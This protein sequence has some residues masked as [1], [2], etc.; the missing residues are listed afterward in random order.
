MTFTVAGE[1]DDER[2]RR[3][4]RET[5]VPGHITV[6]YEREPR[7]F[8]ALDAGSLRHQTIVGEHGGGLRWA[9]SRT[10]D[11]YWINGQPREFGYLGGLRFVGTAGLKTGLARGFAFLRQLHQEDPVPGY[12]TTIV[13]GN[14]S[15]RKVLTS[16]RLGLPTYADF[17]AFTTCMIPVN[18]R[19]HASPGKACR[20]V[21]VSQTDRAAVTEFWAR[22]GR[23]R[24]LFPVRRAEVF[25]RFPG[26]GP[27]DLLVAIRDGRV[28][29]TV[30]V[31]DQSFCRQHRVVAYSGR[32]GRLRWFL[33]RALGVCG[34]PALPAPGEIVRFAFLAM[35]CVA[36]DDPEVF[37]ELLDAATRG[38]RDRGLAF[39]CLAL[40]DRDPLSGVARQRRHV[41]YR[42]RAFL[43]DWRPA[44]AIRADF[45]GGIPHLEPALL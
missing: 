15:A 39:V 6:A 8:D 4:A 3:L 11:R 18:R 10:V 45:G 24:Q 29:G 16:G 26:C 5:P 27:E 13:D 42:G 19:C 25:D 22:E 34:Y 21:A 35:V 7:F 23:R 41:A 40:H 38:A 33:N 43:V 36:D 31:W 17:G 28:A 1:H 20:I 14:H 37:R 12:L 9:A 30:L 32:L 44:A 2:L